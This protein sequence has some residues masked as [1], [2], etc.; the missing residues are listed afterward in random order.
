M[1][2]FHYSISLYIRIHQLQI[3]KHRQLVD[4]V[5]SCSSFNRVSISCYIVFF[6]PYV[7]LNV[8]LVQITA[9]GTDFNPYFTSLTNFKSYFS[10]FFNRLSNSLLCFWKQASQNHSARDISSHIS[11]A[12]CISHCSICQVSYFWCSCQS[13][14][15]C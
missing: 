5:V 11:N 2:F 1:H 9:N 13:L 7:I 4:L 6:K 12:C 8:M 3:P 10:I 14:F 15:F